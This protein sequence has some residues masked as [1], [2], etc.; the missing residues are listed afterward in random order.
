MQLTFDVDGVS[1]T[2]KRTDSN[3]PVSDSVKF[4]DAKFTVT[5]MSGMSVIPLFSKTGTPYTP[6]Y[7]QSEAENIITIECIVPSEVIKPDQFTVSIFGHNTTTEQRITIPTV[8]VLVFKSG[9]A[10]GNGVAEPSKTVFEQLLAAVQAAGLTEAQ[11]ESAVS[12]YLTAHPI[13]TLTESDVNGFITTFF[14]EHKTELKGDTG[15]TG[16]TG[17]AGINGTNGINGKSAY[18]IAVETGYTGTEL[19]WLQSLVGATGAT[20]A[21]GAKGDTG[22][23]G[24]K[25]DKGDTGATGPAG[26]DLIHTMET[27]TS[28]GTVSKQLTANVFCL[29]SGTIDALTLTTDGASGYAEY[30]ARF[31]TGSSGA[32]ITFPTQFQGK[33]IGD[34]SISASKTYEI[35]MLLGYGVIKALS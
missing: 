15:A 2:I 25:G 34:T 1:Q 21:T 22:A 14:N 11:I 28:S 5:G 35:N 16:A 3:N 31:T 26:Q 12:T 9:Y 10:D 23:Q 29:F 17:T 33:I 19:Q 18:E 8:T 13:A 27:V 32:T 4:L 7:T 24:L 20:G 6:E 30:S